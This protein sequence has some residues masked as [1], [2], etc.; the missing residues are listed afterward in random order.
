M[1]DY[2]DW[3]K[4][5]DIE[6]V[7]FAEM[8]LVGPVRSFGTLDEAYHKALEVEKLSKP[9]PMRR[10]TPSTRSPAQVAF[11]EPQFSVIVPILHPLTHSCLLVLLEHQ[12]IK[13]YQRFSCRGRGHYAFEYPHCT[14]ALEHEPIDFHD[15]IVEPELNYEDLVDIENNLLHEDSH[16][17]VM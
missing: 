6:R 3:Y 17:G 1:E 8:K 15:E 14:L 4:T 2:F 9:V 12:R 10:S 5:S 13:P 7:R 11:K 16:L